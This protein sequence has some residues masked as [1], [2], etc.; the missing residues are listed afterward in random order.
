MSPKI[1]GDI[2]LEKTILISGSTTILSYCSE[3]TELLGTT[4]FGA[5]GKVSKHTRGKKYWHFYGP[6]TKTSSMIVHHAQHILN[7]FLCGYRHR[8]ALSSNL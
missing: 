4:P 8:W 7:Y 2:S 1:A 6:F 5:Q 3:G